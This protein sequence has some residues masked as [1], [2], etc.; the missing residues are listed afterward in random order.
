MGDHQSS[1]LLAALCIEL[2]DFH[3]AE[4]VLIAA[5]R[6]QMVSVESLVDIDGYETDSLS[7]IDFMTHTMLCILRNKVGDKIG[8]R[9][10]L[11][12][13]VVSYQT[14][15]NDDTFGTPKRCAVLCLAKTSLYCFDHGLIGIAS[16]CC[17]MADDCDKATTAKALAKKLSSDSPSYIRHYLKKAQSLKKFHEG[18]FITAATLAEECACVTDDTNLQVHGWVTNAQLVSKVAGKDTEGDTLKPLSKAFNLGIQLPLHV[19]IELARQL[20]V[21]TQYED[22]VNVASRGFS[23]YPFS[24]TLAMMIGVNCLRLERFAEAESSLIEATLLDSRNSEVWVYVSLL[25]LAHGSSRIDEATKCLE[26]ALRHGSV[27]S[28]PPLL[29]EL[30]SAFIAVD[31]LQ[32]AEDLIRRTLASELSKDGK[33]HPSS[34][35]LLADVLASQNQTSM[36][37][38]EYQSILNDDSCDIA[39]KIEAAEKC[40]H[41]LKSLGRDEEVVKLKSILNTLKQIGGQMDQ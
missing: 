15:S 41:H 10:A 9:R 33:Y 26:Q 28:K 8:A 4:S 32:L 19:Y 25:C 22:S 16:T 7:P 27:D 39:S 18:D 3:R 21:L 14:K 31:K 23:V 2:D 20:T 36:A 1:L 37:I 40:V 5:I 29:R 13:A 34:R 17:E 12:L 35:K 38:Q 6:N 11:R 30:A 24:A